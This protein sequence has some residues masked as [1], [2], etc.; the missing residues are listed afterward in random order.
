MT[1]DR[2]DTH[3]SARSVATAIASAPARKRWRPAQDPALPPRESFRHEPSRPR[4][5][6]RSRSHVDSERWSAAPGNYSARTPAP[7][8]PL[9]GWTP[10]ALPS[11][12]RSPGRRSAKQTQPAASRWRQ[13]P[14]R[15]AACSNSESPVHRERPQRHRGAARWRRCSRPGWPR[16]RQINGKKGSSLEG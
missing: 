8:I 1:G 9:V 16:R 7:A 5:Y 11:D 14:D 13:R 2:R 12:S 3:C 4:P 6:R 15:L 10:A